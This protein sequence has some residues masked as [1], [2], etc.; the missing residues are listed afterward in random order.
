MAAS[1]LARG[2]DP[3]QTFDL[4]PLPVGT[5]HVLVICALCNQREEL[6]EREALDVLKLLIRSGAQVEARDSKGDTPLA[7]ALGNSSNHLTSVRLGLLAELLRA[8]ANIDK[9]C[10]RGNV[11]VPF[12]TLWQNR[13]TCEQNDP[14]FVAAKAFM[15]EVRAAGSYRKWRRL[16][17]RSVARLRSLVVRGRAT[18]SDP[19]L[20]FILKL[21]DNGLFWKCLEFWPGRAVVY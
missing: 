2:A 14:S 13:E 18:T 21:G 6:E 1:S 15:N 12:E 10:L 7:T 8:G 16:P 3:N 5:L 19:A 20:A 9:C 17:H 11:P 4:E